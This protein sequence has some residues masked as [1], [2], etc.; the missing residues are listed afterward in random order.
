[1][2]KQAEMDDDDPDAYE[3]MPGDEEAREEGKVKKS[4]HTKAYHKKFS[5]RL[6]TL[7]EFMVEA[8]N[9]GKY[10]ITRNL[11]RGQ[12]MSLVKDIDKPKEFKSYK[13]A[14]KEADRL[15]RGSRNMT[16]YFVSDKDMKIV[17]ESINEDLRPD[18]LEH[19]AKEIANHK[20]WDNWEPTD[21]EVMDAIKKD[22]PFGKPLLQYAT[23]KQKKEAV[24]I[25]QDYLAESTIQRYSWVK[26]KKGE[27]KGEEGRIMVYGGPNKHSVV[28]LDYGEY[29]FNPKELELIDEAKGWGGKDVVKWKPEHSGGYKYLQIMM[30]KEG[31]QADHFYHKEKGAYVGD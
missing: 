19:L 5:E 13:D 22:K 18:E 26:V 10:Y 2:K 3:E 23:N 1:M 24:K 27:H 16:S 17:F 11:G 21:K 9:E 14:K 4:K 29:N 20:Q 8:V 15:E 7:D 12:G 6:K 25:I 31:Y 30:G 28:A